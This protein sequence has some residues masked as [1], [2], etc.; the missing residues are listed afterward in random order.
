[1]SYLGVLLSLYFEGLQSENHWAL[2]SRSHFSPHRD[3]L[4]KA[5]LCILLEEGLF[6]CW[7]DCNKRALAILTNSDCQNV[8]RGYKSVKRRQ[9]HQKELHYSGLCRDLSSYGCGID[10][11]LNLE[12]YC[13]LCCL[14]YDSLKRKKILQENN[15]QEDHALGVPIPDVFSAEAACV[16]MDWNHQHK[17]FQPLPHRYQCEWNKSAAPTSA[18]SSQQK[19]SQTVRQISIDGST[20]YGCS[21]EFMDYTKKA[22][23][24]LEVIGISVTPASWSSGGGAI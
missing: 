15:L 6:L 5:P 17:L 20:S 23:R 1:M 13:M 16:S 22:Q 21:D 4:W 11:K 24:D 9:R 12:V 8:C 10:A 14:H 7:D 3:Q 18:T 19:E 2:V